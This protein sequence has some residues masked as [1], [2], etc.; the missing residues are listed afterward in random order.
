MAAVLILAS[1]DEGRSA[2]SL[3]ARIV[4][5]ASNA[6]EPKWFT[7]AP[8]GAIEKVLKMAGWS[9]DTDPTK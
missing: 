1:A 5:Q 3:I 9:K 7:T 6:Q 8:V 4:A 2:A